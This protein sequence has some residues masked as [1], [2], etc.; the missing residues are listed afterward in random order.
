MFRIVRRKESDKQYATPVT[1]VYY[2]DEEGNETEVKHVLDVSIHV[3]GTG[4][5]LKLTILE[6]FHMDMDELEVVE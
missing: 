1:R 3:D 5:T 2:V 4:A 6:D